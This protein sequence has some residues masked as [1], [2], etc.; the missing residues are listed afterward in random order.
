MPEPDPIA[1]N[2]AAIRAR[3]AAAASEAGRPA[4]AVSLLAVSKTHPSESILAALAAG[5][6]LFGENRVQEAAVKFTPLRPHHPALRL[7]LIGALQTNKAADAV[8]LFDVIHCLD[9]LR[10]ADALARAIERQ[11]RRPELL[12][13]V[14]IGD[15][16]Q[17][18][19]I[20]T[21]E[22][23]RFVQDCARRFGAL[24]TGLMAIPPA[25]ADPRP[26][27]DRLATLAQRHALPVVSMGMSGDYEA[28][29]AAGA[30]IVRV[31]S[32]LFGAWQK[33]RGFAPG[34]HQR[35]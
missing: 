7:H 15:E 30:T 5:Q 35:L 1:A 19:G 3:I 11:G 2:L 6:M 8:A 33:A 4:E 29:I 27:F 32:A 10:L 23:D 22:A 16:P 26:F 34:P 21:A 25:E 20:P 13:Q 28:A 24:L 31:G 14:N 12:V 18:A 9:R 17:K